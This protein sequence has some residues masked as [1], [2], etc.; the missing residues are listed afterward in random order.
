MLG[1][2]GEGLGTT[3]T[4]GLTPVE[5]EAKEL[6]QIPAAFSIAAHLGVGWPPG[7]LPTRLKRRPVEE[8]TTWVGSEASRYLTLPYGG[9][10][11]RP[12]R[13]SARACG[14]EGKD[15]LSVRAPG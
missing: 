5:A 4:A 6:L 2:R 9:Q 14:Y 8:F 1:L 13:R 3:L 12:P 11:G 15:A 10:G 7:R